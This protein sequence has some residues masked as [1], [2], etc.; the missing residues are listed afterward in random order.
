M[1]LFDGS[2]KA[3]GGFRGE[4][5]GWNKTSDINVQVFAHRLDGGP[6]K[7]ELAKE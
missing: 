6:A 3:L 2:G 5:N 4:G 1:L 7:F